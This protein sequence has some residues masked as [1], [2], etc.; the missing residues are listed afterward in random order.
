MTM[1]QERTELQR[2]KQDIEYYDAHQKELLA[3]YP[4][5]YVAIFDQAVVGAAPK[6]ENLLADLAE[7]GVPA[8]QA[9]VRHVTHKEETLILLCL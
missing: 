9:L 3:R 7:R 5:E 8:A 1:H 4:E 2:F 6:L